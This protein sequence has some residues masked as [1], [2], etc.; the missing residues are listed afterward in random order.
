MFKAVHDPEEI[1][2]LVTTFGVFS[3]TFFCLTDSN[4]Q[5]TVQF[6]KC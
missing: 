2:D 4:P 5:Q 3:Y 1:E 6:L